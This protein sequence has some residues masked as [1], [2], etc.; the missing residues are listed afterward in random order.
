MT[1]ICGN[2]R[3]SISAQYRSFVVVDADD[4]FENWTIDQL[5]A[6][7]IPHKWRGMGIVCNGCE[8]KIMPEDFETHGAN[9][10]GYFCTACMKRAVPV[11]PNAPRAPVLVDIPLEY[12]DAEFGDL[13]KS[14]A[15]SLRKWPKNMFIVIQGSNGVGKTRACWAIVRSLALKSV[16]VSML[17]CRELRARWAAAFDRRQVETTVSQTRFLILDDFSGA[18]ATDGWKEFCE[19]LL[20]Q[21]LNRHL[22]TIINAH[23]SAQALQAKFGDAIASRLNRFE[24]VSIGG[25]DRRTPRKTEEPA[26]KR[27]HPVM[28][29]RA[30]VAIALEKL[31]RENNENVER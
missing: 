3:A 24:R 20:D 13:Q 21:R 31:R 15:E 19:E 6:E 30:E 17:S 8:L 4:Q 25:T 5:R 16:R 18:A 7:G 14:A 1:L 11:N 2:V 10:S 26:A 29:S 12:A 9:E 22:P 27:Q 23:S 28:T